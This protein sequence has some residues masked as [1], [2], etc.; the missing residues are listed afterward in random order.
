MASKQ[1]RL[2][3]AGAG[4]KRP[5]IYELGHE[6][7]LVTNIRM[8]AVERDGGWV[9]LGIEGES[10]EIERGLQWAREHGVRVDDATLGDIVEG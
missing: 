9:V 2:T 4:V 3:F 1:V 6:F 10:D 5:L 8:A 7:Q